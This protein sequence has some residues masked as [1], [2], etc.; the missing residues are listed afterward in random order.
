MFL[1]KKFTDLKFVFSLIIISSL[2]SCGGG[3]SGDPAP[4]GGGSG[5]SSSLTTVTAEFDTSFG[6]LGKIIY[7]GA[8]GGTG[9]DYGNAITLD[10]SGRILVAGYRDSAAGD[11]EVAVWRYTTAGA[12]DSSFNS[13]GI[14]N[15]GNLAGGTYRFDEVSDITLDST[16]R[17]LVTGSSDSDTDTDMFVL[18]LTTNGQLDATFG[19][20]YDAN[21]TPDGYVVYDSGGWNMDPS[22]SITLDASGNILITGSIPFG[23][24]QDMAILRFTSSGVL[25]SSF[26]VGGVVKHA[27]SGYMSGGLSIAIDGS[28]KIVVSGYTIDDIG[29][30]TD[31]GLWRFHNDGSIDNSFGIDYDLDTVPDGYIS[32]SSS[33]GGNDNDYARDLKI[34]SQGRIVVA[35]ESTLSGSSPQMSLWR[36]SA[37][38]TLDDSFNGTGYVSYSGAAG[39]DHDVGYA[40]TL[41]SQDNIFIAGSSWSPAIDSYMT[42]WSYD[43]S[44]V[45]NT[46]F[47]GDNKNVFIN[48]APNGGNVGKAIVMDISG[49]IFVAGTSD[50]ST[51]DMAVWKILLN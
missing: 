38:G 29:P 30:G 8:G 24:S 21:L 46:N 9:Y 36:F 41:D 40:L 5:S 6:T 22:F 17:I 23:I 3:G 18:R 32:V 37:N 45:P 15:I 49:N 34:D 12:I 25:D 35:G 31:L 26:G 10:T 7:D 11:R 19:G 39:G 27:G 44:G 28:G 50:L 13:G 48:S 1:S 4:S 43:S 14:F 2:V 51:L 42:L 20:D 47:S 16:G 33:L